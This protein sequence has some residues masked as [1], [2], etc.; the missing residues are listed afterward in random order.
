MPRLRKG[1]DRCT[2][3][4]R[5]GQPC[6]APAIPE[7][8]VCLHHGGAAPQVKIAARHREMQLAVYRAVRDWE[9]AHGTNRAFERL[10]AIGA[11]QR[12]LEEY[13]AKLARLAELRPAVAKRRAAARAREQRTGRA[14]P[15]ASSMTTPLSAG[16]M[17]PSPS[18]SVR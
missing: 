3:T 4:R 6:Q 7:G 9:D 12:D 14:R 16:P 10:C 8:L 11:A 13:E 15:A 2:A 17:K 18:R 1:R 5:D